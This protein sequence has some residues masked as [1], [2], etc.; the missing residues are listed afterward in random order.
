MKLQLFVG[1]LML[2]A[3]EARCPNGCSGNGEC[4]TNSQCLCHRNFMGADCSE[5]ICYFNYAFVDTPLG[6][7]NADGIIDMKINKDEKTK[8]YATESYDRMYGVARP[9]DTS[10]GVYDLD[11]DGLAYNEAM[12]SGRWDEAHFYRECSNKGICNRATGQCVCFPGYEGEGCQRTSC[13]GAESGSPC[14]GHGLC[15]SAYVDYTSAQYNLWDADKTMKCKCDAGYDG[16]DCSLRLC[17]V[18][19]DPVEH[20]DKVTTSLQKISWGAFELD[21]TSS[22]ATHSGAFNGP[23]YF[24]IT[25][26]DDFGDSWTTKSLSIDYMSTYDDTNDFLY[27]QPVPSD[28]F[29]GGSTGIVYDFYLNTNIAD[30]VNASVRALP[31]NAV[32]DAYVWMEYH[33]LEDDASTNTMWGQAPPTWYIGTAAT[34]FASEEALRYPFSTDPNANTAYQPQSGSGITKYWESSSSRFPSFINSEF[35]ECG[36][37]MQQDVSSTDMAAEGLCI[38]ISSSNKVTTNYVVTYSTNPVVTVTDSGTD[39]SYA[40]KTMT[41]YS[42]SIVRSAV[43]TGTAAG[44]DLASGFIVESA[45]TYIDGTNIPVVTVEEVGEHR[46]WDVNIDGYPKMS[47]TGFN[48]DECSRRGLCDYESGECQCFSGYTGVA[49][50]SQN[51]I[52]FS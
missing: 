23:L 21:T 6:D 36:Q 5:R 44:G 26:E 31:N 30:D 1:A 45:G 22:R 24:T 10:T 48:S 8:N 11:S 12:Q 16:P 35:A 32:A 46:Y 41:G 52:S 49:C 43:A 3:A 40:A 25:V 33:N 2:G 37:I 14:S 13:P 29:L 28:D 18:G 19:P 7:I 15:L 42:T 9:I 17:P 20:A 38:F 4:G 39:S 51:S 27:S 50:S 34:A 47:Y